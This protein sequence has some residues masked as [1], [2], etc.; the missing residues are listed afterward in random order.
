MFYPGRI[1]PAGER[2][3]PSYAPNFSLGLYGRRARECTS[4]YKSARGALPTPWMGYRKAGEY[5]TFVGFNQLSILTR[6]RDATRRDTRASQ[7]R[8]RD[9]SLLPVSRYESFPF[10]ALP[11]LCL[12][13]LHL[14]AVTYR[15]DR[16][17]TPRRAVSPGRVADRV[18]APYNPPPSRGKM[19]WARTCAATRPDSSN[20]FTSGII[21]SIFRDALEG[22]QKQPD[23]KSF[24]FLTRWYLP[25]S[26]LTWFRFPSHLEN[27]F[28]FSLSFFRSRLFAIL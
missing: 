18:G 20:P 10:E 11:K 12:H 22:V 7:S 3:I 16:L 4:R 25:S 1:S 23:W 26:Y 14:R 24:I 19:T 15:P 28:F 8:G 6:W 2:P 21:F 9:T 13:T 5:L 17:A 27:F